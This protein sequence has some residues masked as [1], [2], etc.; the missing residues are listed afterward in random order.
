MGQLQGAEFL[1]PFS[2]PACVKRQRNEG[3]GKPLSAPFFNADVRQASETDAPASGSH[4]L[5]P[6]STLALNAHQRNRYASA[7]GPN[8]ATPIR[9]RHPVPQARSPRQANPEKCSITNH[10]MGNHFL[11]GLQLRQQMSLIIWLPRQ[12]ALL[13]IFNLFWRR[14]HV[15]A[16][17][18]DGP[19]RWSQAEHLVCTH[20]LVSVGRGWRARAASDGDSQDEARSGPSRHAN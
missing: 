2:T 7:L 10:L 13:A 1:L 5:F 14:N 15:P 9:R 12:H 6:S 4:F 3:V 19:A 17:S 20:H 11:T 8:S 16:I 18:Q